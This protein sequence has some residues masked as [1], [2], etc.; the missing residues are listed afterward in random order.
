LNPNQPTQSIAVPVA[1]MVMLCGGIAVV[2]CPRRGPTMMHATS[3]ATP[4]V[5]CTTIPPAKSKT[6]M[7]AKKPPSPP[8]VMW[9]IGA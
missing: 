8:H 6:P 2:P 9:Q 1:V 7:S 4:A 3:A 5:M